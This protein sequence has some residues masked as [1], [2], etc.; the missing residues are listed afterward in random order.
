MGDSSLGTGLKPRG[1]ASF[2]VE[3]PFLGGALAFLPLRSVL[4]NATPDFNLNNWQSF[5]KPEQGQYRQGSIYV[6]N[7]VT[8]LG[9][10]TSYIYAGAMVACRFRTPGGS[11]AR[12]PKSSRC[13][14]RDHG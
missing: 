1:F 4:M 12:E 2:G 14:R 5:C 10:F 11:G 6:A 8:F 13:G 7:V 3:V 9:R